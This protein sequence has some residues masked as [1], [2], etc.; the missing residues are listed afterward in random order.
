VP[1][2]SL[3]F[4][5][6]TSGPS[7]AGGSHRDAAVVLK[8]QVDTGPLQGS[9]DEVL[10]ASRQFGTDTDLQVTVARQT[11]AISHAGY[12]LRLNGEVGAVR[13]NLGEHNDDGSEGLDAGLV[14]D[15]AGAELTVFTPAWSL[16]GG[17]SI[18]AG[19][20]GH[21]GWRDADHD[22]KPEL[23]AKISIP[24]FTVGACVEKFW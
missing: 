6:V 23:C 3:V 16:T 9:G 18:S 19:V 17:V 13:A 21:I 8:A 4:L 12:G 5:G 20:S 2:H 10:S 22:G 15:L 1:A 24:E 11:E 7:A 14:A